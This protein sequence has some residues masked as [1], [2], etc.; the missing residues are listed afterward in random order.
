MRQSATASLIR[1]INRS[2]ILDL[3]REGSPISRSQIARQL[4]MSLPTVMRIVTDLMD[5]DLVRL[6]SP[7][8]STGGRPGP[9]LEFNGNAYAVVGVDLGG[10]KLFGT[11][12]DLSG[13]IQQ[14]LHKPHA[15]GNSSRDYLE[16]LCRFIESLLDAPRPEAQR[17]RGIGVGVPGLT[18]VPEGVVTWAPS[19]G[20]RDLPLQQILSERFDM[21]V[22][23]ENDVN[24]TALG[25]WGFGAGRGARNLV[26]IAIG[27]GIGAGIIIGGALYRGHHQAAGE[28]GYLLPGI[29]YL[30]RRYEGF[31][32]LESLASGAGVAERAIQLLRQERL[33]VSVD[34]LTA[35][36]VF[37]AARNGESWAQRVV[38]ETVD[39]LSLAI[40]SISALLDPE[41]I[42]LGGG[43][44]RS[45]DMLIEPIL[46][47]IEGVTLFLPHLVSSP[48]GR[49]AA[50][51]GAIMLVL[52]ATTEY[53]VVKRLP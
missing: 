33:P 18:L 35:H 26:S 41:V 45:A 16:E 19:L 24:L 32:A 53:F 11:V 4:N 43:V 44:A 17:I 27:T 13:S 1:N 37:G 29:E 6:H 39:Y 52:N 25:E 3:I 14:E 47:R 12:A 5:D 51:M 10:S 36:E 30:G 2:A 23:V 46:R 21:P 28:V 38:D 15:D 34:G 8:E 40:A 7:G 9:L 20:W 22:F 50:A 48:L 31:G 42:I 49:R